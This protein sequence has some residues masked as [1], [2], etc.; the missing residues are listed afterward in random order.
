MT[1]GDTLLDVAAETVLN[2]VEKLQE[3]GDHE[4]LAHYVPK[5]QLESAIFNGTPCIALCGKV[6]TPTRD[7]AKFPVCPE[8]K[9]IYESF[10]DDIDPESQG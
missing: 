4:R 1:A 3:P 10:E 8:C 6:W 2:P 9:E 7:S 5:E